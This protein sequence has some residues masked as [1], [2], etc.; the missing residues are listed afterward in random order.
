VVHDIRGMSDWIRAVA[1]QLAQDGFIA[2]VPDF[3]SG[4]GPRGWWHGVPGQATWVRPSASSTEA[5]VVARLDVGEDLRRRSWQPPTVR[6]PC[7]ATAGAERRASLHALEQPKLAGAVVYYGNPP[8]ADRGLAV[9]DR[10]HCEDPGTRA[11]ALRRQRRAHQCHLAADDR[12]D[13]A[14]R[15]RPTSSTASRA[16]ATPSPVGKTAPTA[17]TSLSAT[18]HAWPLTLDVPAPASAL[19]ARRARLSAGPDSRRP[20]SPS[21]RAPPPAR[22]PSPRR[23]RATR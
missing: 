8:G 20:R 14:T 12:D 18:Q 1:D 9:P 6:P 22:G 4:K 11:R 23:A 7:W 16:R 17:P 15:R 19:N 21:R 13:D 2:I 10:S 3:L 5:E